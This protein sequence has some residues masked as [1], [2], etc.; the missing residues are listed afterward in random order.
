MGWIRLGTSRACRQQAVEADGRTS[1][2]PAPSSL[3]PVVTYHGLA[4]RH[5]LPLR[6]LMRPLLNGGTL[7]RLRA[8]SLSIFSLRLAS[9]L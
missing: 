8:C 4:W 3:S 5:L 9:S 2:L 7:G 1:S 6:F